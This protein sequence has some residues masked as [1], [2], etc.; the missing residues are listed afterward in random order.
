MGKLAI[1]RSIS[2]KE[3][4]DVISKTDWMVE[5]TLLHMANID[6][7]HEWMSF[8]ATSNITPFL[9]LHHQH[10]LLLLLLS[11][12]LETSWRVYRRPWRTHWATLGCSQEKSPREPKGCITHRHTQTHKKTHF[13]VSVSVCLGYRKRCTTVAGGG[14]WG[15]PFSYRIYDGCSLLFI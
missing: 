6:I 8:Y 13:S 4:Q 14:W 9:P 2:F 7:A 10:L 3:K 11:R 1:T 5:F 12:M 15:L